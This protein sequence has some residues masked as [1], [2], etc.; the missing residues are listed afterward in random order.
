[1]KIQ[2]AAESLAKHLNDPETF[3]I[4]V[5]NDAIAVRINWIYRRE[6]IDQLGGSWEG[7]PIVIPRVS[8]W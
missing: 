4:S 1:M 3:I 2:E 6:E 7:Y 5:E 8:C